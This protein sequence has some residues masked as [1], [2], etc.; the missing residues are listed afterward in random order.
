[1]RLIQRRTAGMARAM[2]RICNDERAF[3]DLVSGLDRKILSPSNQ[4]A[5]TRSLKFQLEC[6]TFR[7]I[8]GRQGH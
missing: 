6:G 5:P 1:M 2:A 3:D 4:S 8:C 7:R